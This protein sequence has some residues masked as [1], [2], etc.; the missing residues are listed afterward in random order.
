MRKI[1][2]SEIDS[3]CFSITTEDFRDN[4]QKFTHDTHAGFFKEN[5]RTFKREY[6]DRKEY[7]TL[8]DAVNK[9]MELEAPDAYKIHKDLNPLREA[10]IKM[11]LAVA[12]ILCEGG[13]NTEKWFDE[14]VDAQRNLAAQTKASQTEFAELR[15]W[16]QEQTEVPIGQDQNMIQIRQFGNFGVYHN[17]TADKYQVVNLGTGKRYPTLHDRERGADAEARTEDLCQNIGC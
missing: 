13:L 15:D 3:H 4:E 9:I 12:K 16:Y 17:K 11:Q 1:I 8:G 10:A 5:T 2:I 6:L 7:P 14:I